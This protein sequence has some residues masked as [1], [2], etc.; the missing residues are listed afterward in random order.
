LQTPEGSS[1]PEVNHP[2]HYEVSSDHHASSSEEQIEEGEKEFSRDHAPI[3]FSQRQEDIIPN[4]IGLDFDPSSLKL[5]RSFEIGKKIEKIFL[6]KA[7]TC[8][9]LAQ[10]FRR[11]FYLETWGLNASKKNSLVSDLKIK[12]MAVNDLYSV[13][14]YREES[15]IEIRKRKT[16]SQDLFLNFDPP[17]YVFNHD[18]L[19]VLIDIT[20]S[21]SLSDH[22]LA[23]GLHSGK[24]LIFD[25]NEMVCKSIFPPNK[26]SVNTIY[27]DSNYVFSAGLGHFVQY[28]NYNLANDQSYPKRIGDLSTLVCA[29][30]TWGSQVYLGDKKGVIQICDLKEGLRIFEASISNG[31][32][33]DLLPDDKGF[34]A[35]T[36]E[37]LIYFEG[38]EFKQK[39]IHDNFKN[40][41]TTL[42]KLDN[43]IVV[44]TAEGEIFE[45]TMA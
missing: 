33:V 10:G 35:A 19:P 28:Y 25:L 7:Q 1:Y 12:G 26:S 14:I 30:S 16:T 45:F 44:G 13:I 2:P 15:I 24:V 8:Q 32:I 5:T 34:F 41:I 21:I 43:S 40:P 22:V 37:A 9:I 6:P 29:I 20:D 11:N 39:L 18:N 38:T 3:S 27:V 42:A 23:V 31:P 17:T 4:R 36:T